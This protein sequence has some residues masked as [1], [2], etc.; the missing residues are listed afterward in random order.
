M[1]VGTR[2]LR[3]RAEEVLA[4]AAQ[5]PGGPP[6]EPA[7]IFA[8]GLTPAD[9]DDDA[10]PGFFRDL[11]LPLL[12][13]RYSPSGTPRQAVESAGNSRTASRF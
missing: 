4:R 11:G 5:G 2:Q 13:A 7:G 6:P 1:N 10:V 3:S 12:R 8:H 9:A